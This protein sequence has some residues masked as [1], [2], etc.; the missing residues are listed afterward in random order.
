MLVTSFKILKG[1]KGIKFNKDRFKLGMQIYHRP[2]SIFDI[3]RWLY[4]V[5]FGI[6]I[7][8]FAFLDSLEI[9]YEAN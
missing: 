4:F 8:P 1:I 6:V 2:D 5:A 7:L 9:I 3:S